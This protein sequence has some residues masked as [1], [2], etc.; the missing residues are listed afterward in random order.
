[1]NN[2]TAARLATTKECR[3]MMLWGQ[4]L[5]YQDISEML[6]KD[7]P[8]WKMQEHLNAWL[9]ELDRRMEEAQPE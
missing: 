3:L 6:A 2:A 8:D 4:Y 5:A 7:T 1:M 9:E